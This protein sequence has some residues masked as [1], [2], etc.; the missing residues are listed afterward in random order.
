MNGLRGE[1]GDTVSTRHFDIS[2][3]KQLSGQI[4]REHQLVGKYRLISNQ[5]IELIN[6]QIILNVNYVSISLL[7][8]SLLHSFI[9]FNIP[10]DCVRKVF[11]P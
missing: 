1:K 8:F 7:I 2:H 11:N 9:T 4:T 10:F 3:F 6:L 5:K